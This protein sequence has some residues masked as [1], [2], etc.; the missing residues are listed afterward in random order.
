MILIE[1]Y[2]AF[3]ALVILVIAPLH[4]IISHNRKQTKVRKHLSE[5]IKG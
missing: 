5:H 2:M 1:A 3:C 4:A